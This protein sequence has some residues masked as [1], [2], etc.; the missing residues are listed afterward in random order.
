MKR[1][2][3]P[4]LVAIALPTTVNTDLKE[5]ENTKYQKQTFEV[6][7]GK[8]GNICKVSFDPILPFA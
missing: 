6:W 7:C 2:L 5:A 1:L 3:L 8:K 4:L